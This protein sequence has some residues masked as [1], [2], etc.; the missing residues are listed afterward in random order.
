MFQFWMAFGFPTPTVH[1]N[2]FTRWT[3]FSSGSQLFFISGSQLFL[4]PAPKFIVQR[5][6]P[7][8]VPEVDG[9]SRLS[10]SRPGE[11][12]PRRDHQLRPG[13]LGSTS[14]FQPQSQSRCHR[15]GQRFNRSQRFRDSVLARADIRSSVDVYRNIYEHSNVVSHG[16]VGI[17]W[18]WKVSRLFFCL[19]TCWR[20]FL[21]LFIFCRGIRVWTILLFK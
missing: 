18:R 9:V 15:G 19:S 14:S 17:V 11:L 12:G 10:G 21:K 8:H 6:R 5:R 13:R 2:K 16:I 7:R 20:R 1:L 3:F 4:A